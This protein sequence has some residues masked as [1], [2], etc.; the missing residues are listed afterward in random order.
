MNAVTA[1]SAVGCG[2]MRW[3]LRGV[4]HLLVNVGRQVFSVAYFSGIGHYRVFWPY[5][6]DCQKRIDLLSAE[7]VRAFLIRRTPGHRKDKGE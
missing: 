3:S 2:R 5:P 1:L 6:A 7:G 4:P